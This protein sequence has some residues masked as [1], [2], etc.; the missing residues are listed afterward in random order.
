MNETN[1]QEIKSFLEY[2]KNQKGLS[3]NTVVGYELDLVKLFEYLEKENLN[4]ND[5][6]R[7]HFRGFLQEL[8]RLKIG[9]SSINRIISGIKSFIRYKIRFGYKDS[10]SILE[11]ESQKR[12]QYLPNFL[13]DDEFDKLMAFNI[14]KKEDYRDAAIFELIFSTG[15]RVSEVVSLNLSHINSNKEIRIIGKGN[16]ERIVLYGEKA[17]KLVNEYI[18][19]RVDF[20]PKEDALFLNNQGR[21]LTDRGIR[22][23]LDKRINETSLAKKISPHSLRHSFATHLIR[24]GADIRSVQTLLGHSSLSTTQI[25]THFDL[26][27][28]KEMHYNFHPHGKK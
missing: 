10:A 1:K 3:D 9:K 12:N 13:F 27:K 18:V 20:K 24:N 7:H 25:Y 4:L 11:V 19:K 2:I 5:I 8:N 16:K 28:L 17:E 21:R 22:F 26:D 6:K 15:L 23:I 14:Q